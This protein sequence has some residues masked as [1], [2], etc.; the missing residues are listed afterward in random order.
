MVTVVTGQLSTQVESAQ[1]HGMQ[2]EDGL[3]EI[4]PSRQLN[5]D[6]LATV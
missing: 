3:A 5:P 1:E 4:L 6:C 2:T